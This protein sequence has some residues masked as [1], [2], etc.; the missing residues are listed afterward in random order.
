LAATAWSDHGEI[1]GGQLAK[2]NAENQV[3][4]AALLMQP[5]PQLSTPVPPLQ[6]PSKTQQFWLP[7]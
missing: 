5:V 6:A 7:P 3:G 1:G 4:Q 2:T